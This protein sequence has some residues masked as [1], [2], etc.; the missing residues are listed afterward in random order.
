MRWVARTKK[1]RRPLDAEPRRMVV[2]DTSAW[3]QHFRKRDDLLVDLL[4]H[5][6]VVTHPFVIGELACGSLKNRHSTL[7]LFK[8]L[9][10][11]PL[12]SHDEV[13]NFVES[14][15]LFAAG[16]GWVDAHILAS[17]LLEGF[18]LY[19]KDKPLQC[20]ATV[21]KIGLVN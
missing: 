1:P 4:E 7:E 21:C 20:A 9:P 15:R 2:V 17:C 8:L 3:I 14:H 10:Q 12:A 11:S 19:T 13:L 5:S 6:R 16:I 18:S